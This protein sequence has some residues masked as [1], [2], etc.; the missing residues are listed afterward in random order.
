MK[1]LLV[2]EFSGFHNNL[3]KG[4]ETLGYQ[5]VLACSGDGFK[6]LPSDINIGSRK[7]G[8][9]GTFQRVWR[10]LHFLKFAKSFDI[11]QFINPNIF[12]QALGFND[13]II[14]LII[15]RNKKTFLSACGDDYAF[16][17][18]G[19][20]QMRYSPIEDSLLYDYKLS[21][22]PLDNLKAKN[23]WQEL[24]NS[25]TGIIPVMHEYKLGYMQ[26]SNLMSCI[27]LPIYVDDVTFT[28]IPPLDVITI[29]HGDNRYG[30]K[31]TRFVEEAF[32]FLKQKYPNQLE[33]VIAGKLPLNEYLALM[34][35]AHIVI[36]QTNSYSCGMN[37]L[38]AMAMG[39]IVLGGA[40]PEGL[41]SLGFTSSPVVNITPSADSIITA[42]ESLLFNKSKITEL[43]IESRRFTQQNHCAIKI[44]K[45]YIEVWNKN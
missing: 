31:G 3:K 43:S 29:F 5:V 41:N 36:D 24:S 15:K 34:R 26:H 35:R 13:F 2:G 23:W 21:R 10:S 25:V 19:R 17:C 42:V 11:V 22:H 14:R 1:V 27:P 45:R 37:A 44:A 4:L 6:N 40:E 16:I 8:L 30:F 39:K 28:D 33:L 20:H 12:P 7:N 18:Y 38:Y 9:M 32:A